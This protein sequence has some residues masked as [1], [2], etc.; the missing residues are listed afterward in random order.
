MEVDLTPSPAHAARTIT[1][2]RK[3]EVAFGIF[4]TDK[5][6]QPSSIASMSDFDFNISASLSGLHPVP[7]T[8]S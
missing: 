2:G 7:K 8:P 5:K 4:L 6:L 1:R 3:S